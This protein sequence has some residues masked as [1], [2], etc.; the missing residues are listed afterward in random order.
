M[1][2]SN[3]PSIIIPTFN[4]AN[5][6]H[7]AIESALAQ[8]LPCEVILVDHGST[9]ATPDVAASFGSRIRYLRREVDAGPIACWRDGV[10][11]ATGDFLHFTFD[12]D[13][14]EPDFMAACVDAFT[15]DAAFVYTQAALRAP[16]LSKIGTVAR[17]PAGRHPVE[18]VVK[19]LLLTQLTLSPG[20]AVFR[21]RDAAR[22]LLPAVPGADGRYGANS[23]VGEDLLLFLLP[24]LEYS[25][26]VHIPRPLASFMAHSGSITIDAMASGRHEQL[27]AAYANA[28]RHYQSLPGA[29]RT[30]TGASA[31][32]FKLAWA[33]GAAMTAPGGQQ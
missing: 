13:W 31:L 33:L 10:D 2:M 14:I 21:R 30:P 26:Y 28:R 29:I 9:D 27:V 16:D 4:R 15:P 8:T 23:G 6:V 18:R 32:L 24:T 25:H 3:R 5:L 12:D 1:T 22:H 17:H 19:H 20:C 11:S 7:R